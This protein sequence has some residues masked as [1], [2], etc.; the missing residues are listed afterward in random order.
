[1][2]RRRITGALVAYAVTIIVALGLGLALGRPMIVRHPS[3]IVDLGGAASVVSIGLGLVVGMIT[4]MST[5]SLLARTR[6]A[7]A[8]RSELKTFVE[9]AS[10]AQLVLLG[11]ASGVAEELLFRGALQPALGYV[12]TSIGFGLLHL[13]PRR[14]LV[15]WTAWAVVMGFVLGGIYELT[16]A[17]EGPIVAHVLINVVNLRVIARHDARL[18]PGD[19]RLEPPKL[20][21]RVRRDR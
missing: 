8:L 6:W 15:P 10:G 17:L 14:D 4:I 13:A 18:D 7:K 16:G 2:S 21:A 12:V 11:L 5:R 1:M 19:G 20:V 9:G 3:A